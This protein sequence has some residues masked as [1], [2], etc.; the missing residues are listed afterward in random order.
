MWSRPSMVLSWNVKVFS[1]SRSGKPGKGRVWG[2]LWGHDLLEWMKTWPKLDISRFVPCLFSGANFQL[3][4]ILDSKTSKMFFLFASNFVFLRWMFEQTSH[5]KIQRQDPHAEQGQCSR[6]GGWCL[7][8]PGSSADR[9]FKLPFYK[10]GCPSSQDASHHLNTFICNYY[11]EGGWRRTLEEEVGFKG[12]SGVM[13]ECRFNKELPETPSRHFGL[14]EKDPVPRL[15][16]WAP[17]S[18]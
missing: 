4:F 17:T 12:E 16:G 3:H 10:L 18:K 1:T 7:K 9:H 15:G 2:K 6:W 13:N 5:P 14:L 11:W 8:G